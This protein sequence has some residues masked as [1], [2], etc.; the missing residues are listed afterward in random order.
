[1][2]GPSVFQ[3][4]GPV[5]GPTVLVL[6]V[7]AHRSISI[8]GPRGGPD[9]RR[10]RGLEPGRIFQSTGPVGGPTAKNRVAER[11]GFI[12]IHGPR[13]GPDLF[14]SCP[15]GLSP[16][17]N[18]R[19]PWGARPE[20]RDLYAEEDISI[21]GPRGGPDQRAVLLVPGQRISIHGPRGG[22]DASMR[23]LSD[24]A[25]SFQSTGPVGGPT[26][27]VSRRY[28]A[29]CY[30]NPRAPWGA[31]RARKGQDRGHYP[32]SIHGPR[33]GP[34]ST[35]LSQRTTE[36]TFQSTGP[37]GGPTPGSRIG[38]RRP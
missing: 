7:L 27:S 12:S 37:V 13:G 33:G 15:L 22:P 2:T 24:W 16:N 6:G 35:S 9:L 29:R 26:I 36:K 31:R 34:D 19:A 21:H 30:F 1:M 11:L 38:K 17:F 18:P 14:Y 20:A 3:S 28:T 8:H 10:G 32:I 4:T 23:S 5:G 25:F